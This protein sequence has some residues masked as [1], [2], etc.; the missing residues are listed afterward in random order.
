MAKR[1]KSNSPQV[2]KALSNAV[3]NL[4]AEAGSIKTGFK[5]TSAAKLDE[6]KKVAK[7]FPE[8]VQKAHEQTLLAL[9][10]ELYIALGEAMESKVWQW[11]YGDGD[12]V[13]TGQL[14]D[15]LSVTVEDNEIKFSYGA[16]YAAVVYYGGYI[17]PYGNRNVKIYMPPRP[18]VKAVLVGGGPVPK[19]P[20][21]VKYREIF[22]EKLNTELP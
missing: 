16:E 15:S 13:D 3:K 22:V 11:D 14:R 20:F 18:W 8:Q 19:F 6:F 21:L 7:K 17:H 1:I 12:I 4:S 9:A 2:L 5:I 10:D